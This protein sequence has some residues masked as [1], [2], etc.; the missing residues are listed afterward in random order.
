MERLTRLCENT[1]NGKYIPY[2]TGDFIGIYPDCTLAEVVERL[3]YYEDLQEQGR[4]IILDIKAIHPCRSCNTGWGYATSEG[5]TTCSE[6][7]ERLK[8]YNEKYKT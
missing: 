1:E 3:A 8:Q 5:C 2:V 7:C 6:T 4:L